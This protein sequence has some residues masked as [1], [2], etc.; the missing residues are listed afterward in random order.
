M[1]DVPENAETLNIT[2]R[3][4]GSEEIRSVDLPMRRSKSTKARFDTLVALEDCPGFDLPHSRGSGLMVVVAAV[5]AERAPKPAHIRARRHDRGRSSAEAKVSFGATS[6][7][8]GPPSSRPSLAPNCRSGFSPRKCLEG[9][10][11]TAYP[12]SGL[13]SCT[14]PTS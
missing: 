10:Q 9:M 1:V 12:Q 13:R 6:W 3:A 14:S 8:R 11:S 4:Q 5:R 7:Q 2:V